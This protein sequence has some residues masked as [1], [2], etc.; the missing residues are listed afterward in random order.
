ME[1]AFDLAVLGGGPAGSAAA[2]VA[3]RDHGR[4]LLL[5]KGTF[6]RQKV[7]GEFVSAEALGLLNGLLSREIEW[8]TPILKIGKTR[9]YLNGRLLETAVS[10]PASSITRFEMDAALWRSAQQAGATSIDSATVNTVEGEGPFE[11]RTTAGT[12]TARAVID[13]T[14]RWSNI[15]RRASSTAAGNIGLKQHFA[16]ASPSLSVDLYF[17]PGGYCGVQPISDHE[18]NVS[19]LVAPRVAK[20]LDE[21]FALE[22]HLALRSKGWK[23]TSEPVATFPLIFGKPSPVKRGL[24]LNAGDAAGFI[25]PFVGDGISMALHSGCMAAINA[26]RFLK[27]DLTLEQAS[28]QY[29]ADYERLLLPAF[30]NAARI[31]RLL[32]SPVLRDVALQLF[33][34]PALSNLAL[35]STRA[36]IA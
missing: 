11:V 7:C 30:R 9:I 15:S 34:I 8:K 35:K 18:I 25:D 28:A 31:R 22:P 1:I 33:R 21:V 10:P 29:S 16:E 26:C 5:E 27:G 14:G 6:P 2:I 36:R 20:T 19:A 23:P 17:F 32:G 4:V 12:F 3:A 24:I 13:A